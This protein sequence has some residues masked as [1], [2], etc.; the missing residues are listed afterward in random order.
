MSGKSTALGKKMFKNT[1]TDGSEVLSE[2]ECLRF[3]PTWSVGRCEDVKNLDTV[4][5]RRMDEA[6]A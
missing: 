1:G 2:G 3:L 5:Y 4:D 6:V